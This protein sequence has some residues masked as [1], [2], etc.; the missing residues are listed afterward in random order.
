MSKIQIPT[1]FKLGPHEIKISY[2]KHMHGKKG[3][4]G[5]CNSYYNTITLQGLGNGAPISQQEQ[6]FYHEKVH[7]ILDIMERDELCKDENFVNLFA[8]FLLQTDKTSEH[9]NE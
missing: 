1:S 8:T 6:T 3:L 9:S 2:E 5:S 4:A 7:L